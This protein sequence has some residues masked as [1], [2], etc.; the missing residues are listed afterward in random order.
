MEP[1]FKIG[2]DVWRASTEQKSSWITCPDC[3]GTLALKVILFDATEYVIDCAGC[4][5][6]YNPPCGKIKFAEYSPHAEYHTVTGVQVRGDS[7]EYNLSGG[8]YGKEEDIF[9][10]RE[11]ALAR[12]AELMAEKNERESARV[13]KKEKDARTWAWRVHYHRREIKESERRLAYHTQKLGIAKEKA[14]TTD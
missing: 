11:G 10:A 14:K 8:Y 4:A 5:A 6:G 9:S 12:S 7:F 13:F 3:G 2:D 1:R